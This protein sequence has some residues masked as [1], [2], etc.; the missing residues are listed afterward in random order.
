MGT[1]VAVMQTIPTKQID[2][3]KLH[4]KCQTM[5]E[6]KLSSEEYCDQMCTKISQAGG[7][8]SEKH[9]PMVVGDE[10]LLLSELQ[11]LIELG[12]KVEEDFQQCKGAHGMLMEF[13]ESL[14]PLN[15][16]VD[17]TFRQWKSAKKK[18]A[19]ARDEMEEL[20]EEIDEN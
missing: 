6:G 10:T 7:T 9:F 16:Q 17:Y 13:K 19:M 3:V 12:K 11:R 1:F 4:K 20:G 15:V 5:F 18:L 14:D 2:S 8:I